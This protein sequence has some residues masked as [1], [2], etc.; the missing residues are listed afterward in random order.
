MNGNVPNGPGDRSPLQFQRPNE[1]ATYADPNYYA[2]HEPGSPAKRSTT[3]IHA[4]ADAM[5]R[6]V[7]DVSFSLYDSVD[8]DALDSIFDAKSDGTPRSPGHIAFTV[9]GYRVTVYSWGPIVITPPGHE[10]IG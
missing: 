10:E 4:L 6:D 2:F 7:S 5:G 1:Y 8:P 9:Q 3:V